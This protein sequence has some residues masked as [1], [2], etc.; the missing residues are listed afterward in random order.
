MYLNQYFR[1]TFVL[2]FVLLLFINCAP[3]QEDSKKI[4]DAIITA[5]E[6]FMEKV[7]EGN[8]VNLAALYTDNGQLLPPNGDFLTGREAIQE[9]W[10]GN[11]DSGV[12]TAIFETIEVE[13]L[14]ETAYEVGTYTVFGEGEQM[15]DVGKYIVIWKQ[16]E[17][18]WKIHRDIW[19]TS[20]PVEQ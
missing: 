2:M 3:T 5:N 16:V 14:G 10:Q 8:A 6:E 13:G 18:L 1:Y 20:I 11:V 12:R 19:N 7:K 17:G 4:R 15:V 9:A